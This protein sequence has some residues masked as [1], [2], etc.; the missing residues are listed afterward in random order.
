[1]FH[2]VVNNEDEFRTHKEQHPKLNF[3]ENVENEEDD[4]IV[5]IGVEEHYVIEEDDDDKDDGMI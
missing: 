3:E 2:K 5:L 1:M 4:G